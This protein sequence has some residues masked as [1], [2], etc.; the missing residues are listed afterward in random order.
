MIPKKIHYC[1][2]GGKPLPYEVK[3]CIKSWRKFCPDYQIVRW[4]ETN[5]NVNSHPFCQSAYDARAWAF[6]SDYARLKIVYEEGGI[7]LDTDVELLKSLDSLLK[8]DCYLGI[9]QI[10]Y[11]CNT[12]LGFGAVQGSSVIRKMLDEYNKVQF[13]RNKMNE[14]AC[15]YLNNRVITELGYSFCDEIIEIDGA[16]IFPPRY[17]DPFAPGN[18]ARN[19]LCDETV[20]IHH[21]GN[22]WGNS[23]DRLK[24][25][26]IRFVGDKN[27][28][29]IKSVIYEN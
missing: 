22:S 9:E 1:W 16:T 29:K 10:V 8:Y 25:R 5:F 4:D 11:L 15:P 18:K 2:F 21:Y 6:V 17:F 23:R 20:S 12:G 3:Q 13:S 14:I 24:R 7:Y 19:L 28:A 26:I 27:I